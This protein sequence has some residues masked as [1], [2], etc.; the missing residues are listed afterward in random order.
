M[1]EKGKVM[2]P[3]NSS[4]NIAGFRPDSWKDSTNYIDGYLHGSDDDVGQR[5][6]ANDM[7]A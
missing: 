7:I 2:A 5:W 6:H 4:T 1:T 3:S